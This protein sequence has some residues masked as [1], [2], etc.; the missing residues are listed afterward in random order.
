M[1]DE[2]AAERVGICEA[3]AHRHLLRLLPELQ[4]VPRSREMRASSTQAAGVTPISS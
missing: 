2:S 3:A 1:A 4:E